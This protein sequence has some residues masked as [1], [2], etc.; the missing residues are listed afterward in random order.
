MEF[1]DFEARALFRKGVYYGNTCLELLLFL[2]YFN[3]SIMGIYSSK[4]GLSTTANINHR[5]G[6]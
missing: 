3:G 4:E 5:T 6:C 1:L 2:P